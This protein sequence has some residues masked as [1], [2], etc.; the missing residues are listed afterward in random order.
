MNVE[1]K[2]LYI[3]SVRMLAKAVGN[4]APPRYISGV[5]RLHDKTEA[6]VLK[7]I[8]SQLRLARKR[9]LLKFK[10]D[11]LKFA[12]AFAPDE[13]TQ[14]LTAILQ[15][16]FAGSHLALTEEL[17]DYARELSH[18]FADSYDVKLNL[19]LVNLHAT[20]F[21]NEQTKNYFTTLADEQ[22][23]GIN[24]AIAT[25]MEAEDGYTIKDIVSEIRNAFGKDT[26][27]FPDRKLDVTDWAL[28]VARSETARAAS[29]ATKAT[30]ESI[31]MHLWQWRVQSTCCNECAMNDEIVIEIGQPFPDGSESSPAHPNCRCICIAVQEEL[32]AAA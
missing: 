28:T 23:Q 13:I 4:S 2:A 31:G 32:A 21:L 8:Q 3:E 1:I 24:H 16:A 6:R 25:A 19:E 5:N 29:F 7:L 26:M 12:K 9:F 18:L 22:A 17:A 10:V 20:E 14:E 27:Y 30:L 11:K 15:S